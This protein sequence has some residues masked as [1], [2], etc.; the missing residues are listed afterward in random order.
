M[1]RK[2]RPTPPVRPP[3]RAGSPKGPAAAALLH[4]RPKESEGQREHLVAAVLAELGEDCEIQ[5]SLA[6][7]GG[8]IDIL[9]PTRRAVIEVKRPG[10]AEDPDLPQRGRPN[11][12]TP[13]E[14]MERYVRTEIESTLGTFRFDDD[15]PWL[16][17][18]T[19]GRTWWAWRYPPAPAAAG[20]LV[21]GPV[22]PATADELL[23]RLG[24]ALE[25][26]GEGLP[27]IPE[28][29]IPVFSPDL[30]AL[31]EI[32]QGIRPPI[33]GRTE[34]KMR[35]WLDML[36]TS[37]MAPE[38]PAAR[39]SLFV[40]HTFLV[41]LARCV[42]HTLAHPSPHPARPADDE[43]DGVLGDGFVAW[44]IDPVEGRQW[45]RNL[46]GK[47]RSFEWRRRPGDVMRPLYEKFVG[48]GD[49]RAFGEFY[50]PDWLAERIV[51]SVCDEEWCERSVNAAYEA[52]RRGA[53]LHGV[54]VLDP[55]CGSGTFLHHA[56]ARIV[57]CQAAAALERADLARVVC[58]LV[59]GIDIHPVAAEIARATLMRTLPQPVEPGELSIHE[60]D[61]LMALGEDDESLFRPKNGVIEIRSP[62]GAEIV[63]PVAFVKRREFP[64][65]LRRMVEAADAGAGDLPP[66]V[67]PGLSDDDAATVEACYDQLKAVIGDEG[68]SVWTWF[69]RNIMGP[70]RLSDRRVDRIV[71]NPPWVKMAGVQDERRKRTLEA[72]AKRA[73]IDLWQGGM[74][75]PHLDLAQMFIKRCRDRYLAAAG[76]PAAWLVKRSALAGGNWSRFREWH[77]PVLA[78]TVDLDELRPFGA[79]DARR[80][81]ILFERR[82][83]GWGS[84]RDRRAKALVARRRDDGNHV[85]R[86]APPPIPRAPSGYLD[87]RGKPVF[88]QGAIITPKVLVVVAEQGDGTGGPEQAM[89]TTARSDKPEWRGIDPQTG[90]VP[91]RWVAQ[92]VTSSEVVPFGV[93]AARLPSC[94]APVDDEGRLLSDAAAAK[95][96][97]WR[98][99]DRIW[100][101]RRSLGKATPKTL[102][103]QIDYSSKLSAQLPL[104]G[105]GRA[106]VVYPQSGDIMR[107][108]RLRPSGALIESTLYRLAARSAGEAA[109]LAAV[110]NAPCLTAAFAA[111][112][113]SGRHFSQHPWR[114][115]PIPRYDDRDPLHRELAELGA[116]GERVAAAWLAEIDWKTAPRQ[117]GLSKRLRAAL[118]DQGVS[119]RIDAAARQLLPDQAR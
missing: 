64:G 48:E 67:L 105:G 14:Q 69:I 84:R 116:E 92:L 89:I 54:G 13:R 31:G 2:P 20:S 49:R 37:S 35:L 30:D 46:L 43:I 38:T 71:A 52:L 60:G 110:L 12:E 18:L 63:L 66:G 103:G 112:R 62:K 16:G 17:I 15:R 8:T 47:V 79:G 1:P 41:A 77:R 10:G 19:D 68:N 90:S 106:V 56:A 107:A 98:R 115:I 78:Q 26:Q 50:T 61:A 57:N 7:G 104:G 58:S 93:T 42:I 55:T 74:Q 72:F 76:D 101:E 24:R 91:K 87:G 113:D 85:F 29:P 100:S 21:W 117:V 95:N 27:P 5:K 28:D 6:G 96:R 40:K 33:V 65:D 99:V 102:L 94:L 86:R 23:A 118:A 53:E 59:H 34:T 44:A 32:Y 39:Q 111:S 3:A 82:L 25:D 83:S 97:F 51:A 11:D 108:A 22:R 4:P 73:E 81:C 119:G 45:A 70:Y 9:I 88:R 114:R 75:A 109:Y 80:C 36:R